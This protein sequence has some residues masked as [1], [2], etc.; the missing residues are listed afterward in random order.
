ME[1]KSA[2]KKFLALNLESTRKS[3][4]PQLQKEL[5]SSKENEKRLQLLIDSM[6]AQISYV[7]TNQEFALVNRE[8]ENAFGLKRDQIIGKHI[9]EILGESGYNKI[10]RYIDLALSGESGHF[11]IALK[12][13]DSD[14]RWYDFNYVPEI[15]SGGDVNGFYTL[16][17]DLTEKR[18]EAEERSRLKDRL[19]QSQK[20][21]AIGTLASGIAH[22]FNN[23]LSGIFGYSQLAGKNIN[24]PE[25][26]KSYIGNI[27]EGAKRA[28]TLIQQ[29]L[30]FSRQTESTKKPLSFVTLVKDTLA[31]L[32][33]S[34]PSSIEII[35]NLNCNKMIYGDS[36]E[37]HQVVMN[38]C[39]N[40]YHAMGSEG[41]LT[42]GLS[43]VELGEDEVKTLSAPSNRFI[44]LTISDTGHG[45][46]PDIAD[47]IFDPY[48]TTKEIGKGT[49]LGLAVVNGIVK[50]HNGLIKLKG[51]PGET[52][53]EIYFPVLDRN[54]IKKVK[55]K[56]PS[57]IKKGFETIMLVDDESAILKTLKIILSNEGYVV[58]TYNNG[59]IALQA[60]NDD[61]KTFDMVITDMTMPKMT[62]DKL[63]KEILTI[64]EDIPII[65]C[66]GYLDSFTE[67][68]LK[69]SGI[70]KFIQ[71]PVIGSYLLK[72]IRTILDQA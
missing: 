47:K 62:G 35:E 29:I 31:L 50:K 1:Y 57:D 40:A 13:G 38:I 14:L 63:S 22:D 61:P 30:T 48:F 11:E 71:K 18:K 67:T 34:I 5:E 8:Y 32:R 44:M 3:Y 56:K 46:D 58:H 39:T 68:D 7:N 28:S 41:V 6:P 66:S 37:I 43:E 25:K 51:K 10:Q 72:S 12:I 21:E 52:T 2:R 70:S 65:I 26:A 53:F 24:N 45:I 36:T 59:K 16:I 17:M 33:S 23:I 20:M 15:S 64:R 9:K 55:I 54:T 69:T 42:V 27:V 49:G 19:R 60:F 4:Y